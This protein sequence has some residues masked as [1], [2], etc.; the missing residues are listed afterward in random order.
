MTLALFE[1]DIAVKPKGFDLRVFTP[2]LITK[3]LKISSLP[4]GHRRVRLSSNFLPLLGFAAG[5]RTAVED[6]G[7]NQGLRVSFDPQGATKIYQRSY[8]QRKNNPLEAQ[9]DIQNQSIIDRAFPAECDRLHFSLKRG[10]ILIKPLFNNTFLIRTGI[11]NAANP[12]NAFV[13]MTGGVDAHCLRASGFTIQSVL[14][15]RPQ[16]ARDKNDLTETGA[17]NTIS[18]VPTKFLFNEDISKINW[19]NVK[20]TL[21]HEEPVALL[22]ISLQCDDFSNLKNANA[23]KRSVDNL[24]TSA[25]LVYDGL[26]LVETVQPATVIFENVAGFATSGAGELLR[27]K[28][29]KWGYHVQEAVLDAREHNGNTTRKRYYMVASVWPGFEMPQPAPTKTTPIWDVIEKHIDNCRDVSH[30]KAVYDGIACGRS[31]IITKESIY[32][33]TITKSQNRMAKDSVYIQKD[34]RYYFP[35][36]ELLCAL[37]GFPADFSMNAVS[38]TIASEII[39]QSIEYPMHHKLMLQIKNHIALNAG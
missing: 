7:V 15:Y 23:K 29:R 21:Q 13:A 20:T 33:P 4:S 10:A 38:E 6:M 26:R 25:D 9:I 28:L 31:R 36:E 11:K 37:N 19:N 14:E 39:G 16:E 27:I 18:N 17:L 35:N 2:E 8:T 22:H 34:G 24:D 3:E 5:V 30:T 12:F 1:D 32:S